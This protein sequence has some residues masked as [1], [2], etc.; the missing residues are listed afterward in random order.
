MKGKQSSI[1]LYNENDHMD[2]FFR[3]PGDPHGEGGSHYLGSGDPTFCS[4]LA[5]CDDEKTYPYAG[6]GGII[7]KIKNVW[8]K[9][10]EDFWMDDSH[11]WIG[12]QNMIYRR[13]AE[14]Y[15]YTSF[16]SFPGHKQFCTM[17]FN[18]PNSSDTAWIAHCSGQGG[19]V[20]VTYGGKML[21]PPRFVTSY[22]DP[23][24]GK[25][26]DFSKNPKREVWLSQNGRDW[27]PT[28]IKRDY[29]NGS[30]SGAPGFMY[31][32]DGGFY[33]GDDN[34]MVYT[35]FTLGEEDPSIT[36]GDSKLLTKSN[37]MEKTCNFGIG[38]NL[39]DI[40]RKYERVNNEYN[41]YYLEV[42]RLTPNNEFKKIRC[43]E[44]DRN[45]F[46]NVPRKLG[47]IGNKTY[48]YTSRGIGTYSGYR[49]YYHDPSYDNIEYVIFS[50]DINGNFKIERKELGTTYSDERG[51]IFVNG[52]KMD[53]IFGTN[54]A[55]NILYDEKTKY[56]YAYA[57]VS[58]NN[59]HFHKDQPSNKDY[60]RIIIAKTK[61]FKNI[62]YHIAP[63]YRLM[64]GMLGKNSAAFCFDTQYSE[65]LQAHHIFPR[66]DFIDGLGS[67]YSKQDIWCFHEDKLCQPYGVF[68]YGEMYDQNNPSYYYSGLTYVWYFHDHLLQQ[69]DKDFLYSLREWKQDGTVAYENDSQTILNKLYG[70]DYPGKDTE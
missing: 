25:I 30:F 21:I 19:V 42:F 10:Y 6:E 15:W 68:G 27:Y 41:H 20:G 62:T 7:N 5:I 13:Y 46:V 26:Y 35:T 64:T 4:N 69:N 65:E 40:E 16:Y 56:F 18:F 29:S 1:I 24:D 33:L 37:G 28:F 47:K 49:E 70:L 23:V 53:A 58:Y 54:R 14:Q 11:Y 34:V 50:I 39:F 17:G 3:I 55:F 51:R 60:Y 66:Y 52:S 9:R 48:F 2:V 36:I 45:N 61:D 44:G 8:S 63:P 12:I 22:R 38:N 59:V 67:Y 32:V 57:W 43:Y 31:I